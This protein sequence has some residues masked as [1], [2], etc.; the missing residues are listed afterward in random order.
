MERARILLSLLTDIRD[1]AVQLAELRY[2]RDEL[3]AQL[4][5][6]YDCDVSLRRR[7]A[8]WR[9]GLAPDLT[10]RSHE[11]NRWPLPVGRWA[12]LCL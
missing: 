7:Y 2:R 4:H 5:K 9:L 12:V 11:R 10:P 6:I 8:K 1:P 3:Q